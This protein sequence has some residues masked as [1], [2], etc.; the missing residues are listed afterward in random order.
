M[1]NVQ[2]REVVAVVDI[3][4]AEIAYILIKNGVEQVDLAAVSRHAAPV[5]L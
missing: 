2:R 4:P 3:R 5:K 1:A